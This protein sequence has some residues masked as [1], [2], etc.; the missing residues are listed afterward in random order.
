MRIATAAG[1]LAAAVIV[2]GLTAAAQSMSTVSGTVVDPMNSGVPKVTVRLTNPGTAAKYEVLTD[3]SGRFSFVALPAGDY[4]LEAQSPGFRA[5]RKSLTLAGR[6]IDERLQLAIGSL[7]ES[8][9]VKYD[10]QS[11]S[12]P[13]PP[14][15][16][17]A[18][19]ITQCTASSA[20]GN[21]RPPKKLVH[22]APRYPGTGATGTVVMDA[23]IGTDG[24]IKD[25]KV[26]RSANPE[27]DA[28]A[29]DAVRQWEFEATLL[30]CV[31]VD[32][33]MTITVNFA[34]K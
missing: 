8:V 21:I 32:V 3:Q 34:G 7:T 30:N 1:L 10:P 14:T 4:Q 25:L 13:A 24:S 20:G 31:P 17:A 16:A 22:V 33:Y 28:A 12:T 6:D 5:L 11:S 19:P 26:L 15:R 18:R 23:T 29:M 27:L 2:V 9:T